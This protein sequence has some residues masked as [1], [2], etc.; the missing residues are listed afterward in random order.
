MPK[1]QLSL[2]LPFYHKRN[3]R[4]TSSD[5]A[6]VVTTSDTLSTVN[7][8]PPSY[9]LIGEEGT[10]FQRKLWQ[11]TSLYRREALL[12][13]ANRT[14]GLPRSV[15]EKFIPTQDGNEELL[16]LETSLAS[17]TAVYEQNG[18]AKRMPQ[19]K[20]IFTSIA[21]FTSA[22]TT[23][24][25]TNMV[26]ALLW[27]SLCLVFQVSMLQNCFEDGTLTSLTDNCQIRHDLGRYWFETGRTIQMFAAVP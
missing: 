18:F 11:D 3:K 2:K 25:Q 6:S 16:G 12:N 9:D 4:P 24:A 10:D 19:V 26:S 5:T 23:I 27:G 7:T 13:V 15:I 8:Q 17:L 22:I 1:I 21:P 14:S 20:R